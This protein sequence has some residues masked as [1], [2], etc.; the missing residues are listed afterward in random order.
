MTGEH[1][2]ASAFNEQQIRL[3]EPVS[4]DEL[5]ERAA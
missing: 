1:V 5:N 4:L 3:F 2:H